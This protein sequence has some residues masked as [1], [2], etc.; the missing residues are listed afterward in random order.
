MLKRTD[1][2]I[3]WIVY[4]TARNTYNVTNSVLQPNVS[5]AEVTAVDIDV[6]SNGFKLRTTDAAG[7]AS[8]GTYIYAA[9]AT[10]PFKNSLAR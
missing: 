2:A 8:G 5:S 7:N 1:S 3:A 9:F 4:D 10:C 6:L